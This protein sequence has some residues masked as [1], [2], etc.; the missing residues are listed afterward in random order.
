M[1]E[2]LVARFR[3]VAA[4]A[5]PFPGSGY[6]A[7]RHRLLAT[8]AC[9]DLSLARLAEAHFDALA[10][11]HEA[12]CKPVEGALYG[13]WASEVPGHQLLLQTADDGGFTISGVKRFCTGA[14]IVDRALVTTGTT[15]HRLVDLD[16]K[17]NA[18]LIGYDQTSWQTAAFA[19]TGTA[20]ASFQHA[21]AAAA[22]L[23]GDAGFYVGRPG[24]WH[25]ACGPASCWAGGALGLVEFARPASAA[26]IRTRS[27]TS[28]PCAPTPGRSMPT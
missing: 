12:D 26:T 10:I 14:G 27:P 5:L 13:V 18:A 1:R 4:Q 17:A 28:E 11:L 3:E 15:D 22:D 2:A 23:V 7:E 21:R 25:G 24:F 19:Q 8:I 9:E 6:T 16:L 20:T